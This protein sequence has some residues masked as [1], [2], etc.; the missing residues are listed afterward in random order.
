MN[1]TFSEVSNEWFELQKL[2]IELSTQEFY[3]YVLRIINGYIGNL[4]ITSIKYKDLMLIINDKYA[5]GKSKRTLTGIRNTLSLIF[6][7]AIKNEYCDKNIATL[8]DLP[9]MQARH[10]RD[11]LTSDEANALLKFNHQ[12]QLFVLMLYYTGMRRG[13]AL[14]L[15]WSDINFY[16]NLIVVSKSLE[17]TNSNATI[18]PPK[19]E[20]GYREIPLP[21]S[22]ISLLN[23]KRKKP[24]EYIFTQ[25]TTG[26]LHTKSSYCKMWNC[27]HKDF[28]NYLTENYPRI[29]IRRITAH[30]IR[31]TYATLLFENAVPDLI[32]QQIIGHS[33]VAFTRHQYTHLRKHF[34]SSQFDVVRNMFE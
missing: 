30:M 3:I 4:D 19:T 24:N 21:I 12:Y 5:E 28:Q 8:I 9:R 16:D 1:M 25:I 33:D 29:P 26:K 11:A 31:H 23:S 14:A 2:R 6:N 13:E 15:K 7:Y 17:L 22:F 10:R 27:W 34:T 18:K 32:V 20:N